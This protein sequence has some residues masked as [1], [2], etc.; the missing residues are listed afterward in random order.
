MAIVGSHL[1]KAATAFRARIGK[2]GV[3]TGASGW[4]NESAHRVT[5]RRVLIVEWVAF[6][7]M[8]ID[9]LGRAH[10]LDV[11]GWPILGRIAFPLFAVTFAYNAATYGR[12]NV[13]KL[14]GLG[15][16]A[17]P[18]AAYMVG[19]AWWQPN[20]MF[21]FPL[22]W[23]VYRYFADKQVGDALFTRSLV[24]WLAVALLSVGPSYD[25]RGIGVITLA[26][27]FFATRKRWV[28]VWSGVGAYLC[29]AATLAGAP[30]KII[31]VSALLGIVWWMMKWMPSG[32]VVRDRGSWWYRTGFGKWYVIH[33]WVLG[34]AKMVSGG[35]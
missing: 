5:A 7:A 14:L 16:I 11:P 32:D 21:A 17:Q 1:P 26:I 2:L 3:A 35:G 28:R 15:V 18:A 8:I 33:V 19:V 31:P 4:L 34:A 20:I 10:L 13:R 6:V 9:H 25:V 29:F 24:L 30:E 12:C 22:G 27:A 23:A